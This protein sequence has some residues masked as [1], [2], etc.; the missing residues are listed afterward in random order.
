MNIE[1]LKQL[2]INQSKHSNYQKLPELIR[3]LIG[4]K[5]LS[6]NSRYEAERL[7][8]I[9]SKVDCFKKTIVDIGGNTGYFTFELLKASPL[10]VKYY[11][12]NFEHYQFVS[13]AVK[14]LKVENKVE[15]FNSYLNFDSS[16]SDV[17]RADI[18]ILLNVLHH[19][20]DDYGAKNI[21]IVAAKQ[22]ILE[23]LNFMATQCEI[24]IFQLG[25]CWKG[26]RDLMLFENGTKL[27]LISFIESGISKSWEVTDIGIPELVQD[28][29]KY[30]D[31]NDANLERN[32][33]FGEFLNRPL[34]ILKKK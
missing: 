17:G 1:E 7:S 14:L 31:K 19:I 8:Y 23:S 28:E 18:G 29:I 10:K 11:E 33:S 2:Y 34:F 26:N 4:E 27:E 9:L 13:N 24:L 5:G 22:K 16:D 3:N 15:C 25:F 12:G 30:V 21:S 6:I 20:G 32:D